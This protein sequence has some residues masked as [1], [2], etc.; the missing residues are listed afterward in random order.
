MCITGRLVRQCRPKDHIYVCMQLLRVPFNLSYTPSQSLCPPLC[1]L[2]QPPALDLAWITAG[3]RPEDFLI[4][5]EVEVRVTLLALCLRPP[6]NRRKFFICRKTPE[7]KTSDVP[8]I[9]ASSTTSSKNR[10]VVVDS[11]GESDVERSSSSL[12]SDGPSS[13]SSPKFEDNC[14]IVDVESITSLLDQIDMQGLIDFLFRSWDESG[15]QS[16]MVPLFAFANWVI[17]AFERNADIFHDNAASIPRTQRQLAKRIAEVIGSL[18]TGVRSRIERCVSISFLPSRPS[19]YPNLHATNLEETKV[20]LSQFDELCLRAANLLLFRIA[21]VTTRLVC[22]RRYA[23]LT[24]FNIYSSRVKL[25][26]HQMLISSISTDAGDVETDLHEERLLASANDVTQTTEGVMEAA[27]VVP[28]LRAA[29]VDCGALGDAF[30]TVLGRL[31]AIE[32]RRPSLSKDCAELGASEEIPEME[33]YLVQRIVDILFRLCVVPL[34]G[35]KDEKCKESNQ[36]F[37]AMP[38]SPVCGRAQLVAIALSHQTFGFRHLFDLIVASVALLDSQSTEPTKAP[39]RPDL[40]SSNDSVVVI[41]IY[42]FINFINLAPFGPHRCSAFQSVYTD[43]RR[44]RSVAF[45]GRRVCGG[46]AIASVFPSRSGRPKTAQQVPL[47]RRKQCC[48]SL[49]SFFTEIRF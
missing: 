8:P 46:R 14:E 43:H 40:A 15:T 1:S 22:W 9:S 42:N 36:V 47:G 24:P 30:V 12:A 17:T 26:L 21:S 19:L 3:G 27:E 38:V 23:K 6:L 16:N 29:L 32:C 28:P 33:K 39:R 11:D 35:H 18:I 34:L 25:Q 49:V 37:G 2:L 31:A 20:L 45:M 44:P 4:Q 48:R 5:P 7:V 13:S 41:C 10:W